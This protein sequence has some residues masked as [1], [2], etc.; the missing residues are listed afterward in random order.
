MVIDCIDMQWSTAIDI[1]AGTNTKAYWDN[2]QKGRAESWKLMH[3]HAMIK[4]A[5]LHGGLYVNSAN[6]TIFCDTQG[7]LH[8]RCVNDF[9]GNCSI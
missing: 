2:W 9:F 3:S 7:D 8:K 5:H 6:K 1:H 4:A